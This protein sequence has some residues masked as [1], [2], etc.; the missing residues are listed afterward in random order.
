MLDLAELKKEHRVVFCLEL[1]GYEIIF[2]LLSWR[3]HNIYSKVLS[4]SPLLRGKIEDKLFREL[5][6]NPILIDEMNNLPAGIISTVVGVI[7]SLSGD[8]LDNTEESLEKINANLQEAR[9]SLE[10]NIYEQFIL[11]ICQAF[12]S[13]NPQQVEELP[14]YEVLRLVVMAEKI[15]S[16]EE[17]LNVIQKKEKPFTEK[18]FE[19]ASRAQQVDLRLSDDPSP[20][21]IRNAL[22]KQND[23]ERARQLEMIRRVKQRR[24]QDEQ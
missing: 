2:R 12:P 6:L 15:L 13:F 19:D 17:P 3:E 10:S 24:M 5:C 7:L 14:Y 21:E 18:I 4:M 22:L 20:A 23:P 1:A 8:T 11:M 9:E 16:L